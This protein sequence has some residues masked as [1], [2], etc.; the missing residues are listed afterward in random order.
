MGSFSLEQGNFYASIYDGTHLYWGSRVISERAD[1]LWAR[2]QA[3]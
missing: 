1:A 3:V 2:I